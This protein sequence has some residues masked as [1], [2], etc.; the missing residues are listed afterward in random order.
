MNLNFRRWLPLVLLIVAGLALGQD[1]EPPLAEE[2]DLDRIRSAT[3]FVMQTQAVSDDLFVTCVSSGTVVTRGGLVLTNAH[4]VLQSEA[5]PGD[6]FV[7]ALSIRADAPPV[8][9]YRA[10]IVQAASGIDLA[11][12][13][14]DRELDGRPI[15]PGTLVMPFVELAD[16][17]EAQL[18][19][20]LVIVG[21]P[22]LG[23]QSANVLRT[24]I[25]GFTSEPGSA[26]RSWIK[27]SGESIAS[28]MSGGG[29]YNRRGQMIGIPTTAPIST[30][31]GAGSCIP[32]Q[33]SSGDGLVNTADI[34]VPVGGFINVLRPANFA[35]SLLRAASLGL[36]I[37]KVSQDPT[38]RDSGGRPTFSR[39]FFAPS[40][41]VEGMPSTVIESL[42]TGSTDLFLFFDYTNM[43]PETVY[44]L[45]VTV[46]GIPDPTFSLSPVRWSGGERGMWYIG[47]Q[48]Q[49]LPNGVYEFTLSINGITQ[50]S[51]SIIVGGAAQQEP[52][53]STIAFGLLT[54]GS[55]GGNGYVLGTGNAVAAQFIYQNMTADLYWTGRWFYNG[56]QLTLSPDRVQWDAAQ[57][58]SGGAHTISIQSPQGLL[59]GTYRLE[60]YL[61]ASPEAQAL[62]A[63]AD[64]IIAG[65]QEGNLPRIFSD[66]YFVTA[67]A[68]AEAP[69]AL[70]LS[71]FP[72]GTPRLYAIFDWTQIASGTL[73]SMRWLVDG[74]PFY[75]ETLPWSNVSGGANFITELTAPNSIPDGTYTME[76]RIGNVL[77]ERVQAQ[78]GIGQLPIDR[79][80][81]P[82][83]IQLGGQIIDADTREGIPGVTFVLIGEEFSVSDFVWDQS[84]VYALAV[85]DR[86]GRFQLDRPLQLEAP[87]SVIIHAS[88]YLP[89]SRD[90]FE[91]DD[92]TP[93]P[94]D[95]TIE[96]IRDTAP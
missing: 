82:T 11:L 17:N 3:V 10:S 76:L 1:A 67:A 14:I 63:T 29:A 22:D 41:T 46:N 33:D 66:V 12:L 72:A 31:N 47:T 64:F 5:C 59:P 92:E 45:Q 49:S 52:T 9:K 68:P 37:T 95:L 4:T 25:S 65:A 77:I 2:F 62:A 15:E 75:E 35:R 40:V 38:I 58:G 19:D 84:Q 28:M 57:F 6:T 94:L 54:D 27:T 74:E 43:T 78:V 61:G 32:L 89:I 20:T 7:I 87:Y 48:N 50:G 23:N 24:T 85:T 79:F 69:D 81:D 86:S 96:M 71:S 18:D 70:V 13:Q 44:A 88:G 80:A 73:W 8:P 21:Y 53:F 16:S 93:N 30:L 60:L 51:N 90:G 83:G 56:E 36:T 26:N 42:P 91:L 55:V 39:L 34:C